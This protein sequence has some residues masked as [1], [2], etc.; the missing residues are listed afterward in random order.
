MMT[1][2]ISPSSITLAPRQAYTFGSTVSG[3]TSPYSYQW[4]QNG[5]LIS[6]A[7]YSTYTFSSAT[8]GSYSL[9][10][11]VTDSSQNAYFVDQC[12]LLDTWMA[13]NSSTTMAINKTDFA[14]G[15]SSF[16]YGVSYAS[17]FWHGATLLMNNVP[18][19]AKTYGFWF[20]QASGGTSWSWNGVYYGNS[21]SNGNQAGWE[22]SGNEGLIGYVTINGYQY[23]NSVYV[24]IVPNTWYWLEV[25]NTGFSYRWYVNGV[26]AVGLTPSPYADILPY[27]FSTQALDA[28]SG[29]AVRLDMVRVDPQEQYP[30][31]NGFTAVSNT[32]N[33]LVQIPPA[34]TPTVNLPPML[35][36]CLFIAA[37]M[38]I[39]GVPYAAVYEY[40]QEDYV[41]AIAIFVAGFPI[42]IGVLLA[43]MAS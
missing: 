4:Y 23:A 37:L 22:L 33:I 27:D 17:S 10:L 18:K 29:Y 1:A 30:P 36:L 25:V 39:I 5:A 11:G 35:T 7:T 14:S 16:Q 24:T 13:Y 40:K 15:S 20:K 31:S 9:Y 6:G 41:A 34:I 26:F 2:S 38:L 8:I 3:G 19:G 32:A 21:T 12:G 43:A 42:A 28:A